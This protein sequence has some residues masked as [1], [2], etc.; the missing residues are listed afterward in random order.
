[1]T[2][3]CDC[4]V[5]VYNNEDGTCSRERIGIDSIGEC[6]NYEEYDEEDEYADSD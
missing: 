5:C 3:N 6:G 1:M 2:V 4:V